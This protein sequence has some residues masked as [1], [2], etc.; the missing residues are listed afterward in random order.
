MGSEPTLTPSSWVKKLHQLQVA[1]IRLA[2]E[3][4]PTY[5]VLVCASSRFEILHRQVMIGPAIG[6]VTI[7]VWAFESGRETLEGRLEYDN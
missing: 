7:R 1:F 4:R 3:F 6:P 5:L 2:T